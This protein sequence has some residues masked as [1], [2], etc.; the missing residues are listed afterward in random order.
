[1]LSVRFQGDN[2]AFEA[3]E[4][5][6]ASMEATTKRFPRSRSYSGSGRERRHVDTLQRKTRV[7]RKTTSDNQMTS[8]R[9]KNLIISKLCKHFLP[10]STGIELA[11]FVFQ[12]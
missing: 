3:D 6:N 9:Y 5:D 8:S 10:H 1:M 2:E 4:A 11:T 7:P 12:A